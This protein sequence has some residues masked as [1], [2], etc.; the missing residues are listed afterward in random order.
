MLIDKVYKDSATGQIMVS[1]SD[2]LDFKTG[3]YLY[4]CNGTVPAATR[5]LEAFKELYFA[6]HGGM[7]GAVLIGS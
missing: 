2:H 1:S 3:Q 5:T 7:E 4:D 6:N